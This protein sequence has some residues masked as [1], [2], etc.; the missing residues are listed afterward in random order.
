MTLI[1]LNQFSEKGVD[2]LKEMTPWAM[3]RSSLENS[4]YTRMENP[5]GKPFDVVAYDK[6]LIILLRLVR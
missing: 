4:R 5:Y 3:L 1:I 6:S 2:V